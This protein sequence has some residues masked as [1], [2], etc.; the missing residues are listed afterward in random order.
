MSYSVDLVDMHRRQQ[1]TLSLS[2]SSD[3]DGSD[4]KSC[5]DTT[6]EQEETDAETKVIDVDTDVDGDDEADL[7]DL[8]WLTGEDNAYLPKYYLKQDD[9]SDKSEDDDEDYKESTARQRNRIKD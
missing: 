3:T 1:P 7:P 9:N 2:S 6:D 4:V 8:E 5:F